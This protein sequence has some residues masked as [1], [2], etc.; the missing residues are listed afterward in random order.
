MFLG[1]YRKML[2]DTECFFEI[3]GDHKVIFEDFQNGF[4]D[5]SV[6]AGGQEICTYKFQSPEFDSSNDKKLSLRID[7]KGKKLSLRLRADSRF[8]G[9]GLDMGS[10]SFSRSIEGTGPKDVVID[11]HDFKSK[12]DKALKWPRITRFYLSI[13]DEASK[14]RIDLTSKEG[15]EM[16]KSITFRNIVL[17]PILKE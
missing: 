8:L 5:W 3:D 14:G 4:Q 7:P 1:K 17:T 11:R 2:K 9:E 10:F 6:R 13:V 16:L 12:D 15:R